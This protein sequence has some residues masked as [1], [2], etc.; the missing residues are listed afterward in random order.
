MQSVTW[1][2]VSTFT[3]L[4]SLPVTCSSKNGTLLGGENQASLVIFEYFGVCSAGKTTGSKQ[5]IDQV[6]ERNQGLHR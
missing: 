5:V 3:N 1:S 6:S 2:F 4:T